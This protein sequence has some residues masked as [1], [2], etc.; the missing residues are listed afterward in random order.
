[1]VMRRSTQRANGD[2]PVAWRVIITFISD[3]AGP[4]SSTDNVPVL[5]HHAA[6]RSR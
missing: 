2:P 5:L 3:D 1:M 4:S 6:R